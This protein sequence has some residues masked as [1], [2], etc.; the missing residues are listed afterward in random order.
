[1]II[2]VIIYS[3][4]NIVLRSFL[5]GLF[6]FMCTGKIGA[7]LYTS[8]FST[9]HF[10]HI[11]APLYFIFIFLLLISIKSFSNIGNYNLIINLGLFIFTAVIVGFY[12]L[13]DFQILINSNVS[14]EIILQKSHRE[15]FIFISMLISYTTFISV[16]Y[17]NNQISYQQ[18][19]GRQ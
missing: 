2:R 10:F 6:S 9:F 7:L 3:I 19:E 8:F 5:S 16:F 14:W 4:C 12:Y 1:M 17:K 15:G 11:E 13:G 18:K